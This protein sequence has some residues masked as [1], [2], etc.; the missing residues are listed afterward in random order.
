MAMPAIPIKSAIPIERLCGP[1]HVAPPDASGRPVASVQMC[2]ST[3][4]MVEGKPLASM[5]T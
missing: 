5:T 4:Q 2:G 1:L 3:G